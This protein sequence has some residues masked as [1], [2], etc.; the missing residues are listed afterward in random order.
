MYAASVLPGK[1]FAATIRVEATADARCPP[2]NLDV[3]ARLLRDRVRDQSLDEPRAAGR[4]RAGDRAMGGLARPARSGWAPR[5]LLLDPV[6]GLPDLVFTANAALIYRERPCWP[7]FAIR[8][9]RAKSRGRS[10]AGR[11]RLH[12]SAA[13]GG[14][15]LRGGRRRPVLRRHAVRRLSHSQRRA[16]ATSKIGEMLGCRVIPL[17]LVDPYYYHLDTCFCP[18]A[19]GVAIYFPGAFDDYG[20][21]ALAELVAEL[22]AV[23]AEEARVC[24]Q[25][26]RRGQNVVTNTGCPQL[27]RGVPFADLCNLVAYRS[28]SSCGADIRIARTSWCCAMSV[29]RSPSSHSSRSRSSTPCTVK[30]VRC[31][32]LRSSMASPK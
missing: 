30:C 31:A 29:V 10:L 13:A 27:H 32:A 5:S 21:R 19:P 16:R 3:P 15:V 1:H 9:G 18:L 23:A 28:M 2:A 12:A 8:S 4:P 24:L 26:R 14:R 17:E 11:A 7:A 20:R 6:P 25:R 22:I